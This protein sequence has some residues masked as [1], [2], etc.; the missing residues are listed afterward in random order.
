MSDNSKV[1]TF[2]NSYKNAE[3]EAEIS[4]RLL[5]INVVSQ[6]ENSAQI[7]YVLGL[8]IQNYWISLASSMNLLPEEMKGCVGIYDI[9]FKLGNIPFV[10][11]VTETVQL[12]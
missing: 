8:N 9:L 4:F 12:V 2:P 10:Y 7:E 11:T 1:T 6:N 5:G 3:E